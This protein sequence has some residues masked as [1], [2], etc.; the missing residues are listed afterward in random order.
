[1]FQVDLFDASYPLLGWH[2]SAVPAFTPLPKSQKSWW[3]LVG[4]ERDQR[5]C[6]LVQETHEH[7]KKIVVSIY[8]L[9]SNFPTFAFSVAPSQRAGRLVY[10]LWCPFVPLYVVFWLVVCLI[11][12]R[13]FPISKISSD[14]K[15]LQTKMYFTPFRAT[16]IFGLPYPLK[17]M[18]LTRKSSCVNAR[19]IPPTT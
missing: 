8:L 9:S 14:F 3:V 5:I 6:W 15:N 13:F 7:I 10:S 11:V 4:S 16:L 18:N 19:G 1:M 2:V 12:A 17:K